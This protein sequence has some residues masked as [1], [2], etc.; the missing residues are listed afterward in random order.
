MDATHD[1]AASASDEPE[2]TAA[3]E[4]STSGSKRRSRKA[5][6]ASPPDEAA[7]LRADLAAAEAQLQ[8]KEQLV[9]ALTERLEQAAE[10]LDRVHRTGGDRRAHLGGF[11]PELV[12]QQKSLV[13]ELQHA[14]ETWEAMQASLVLGRLEVQITELRDLVSERL[15]AAPVAGTMPVPAERLGSETPRRSQGDDAAPQGWEA[16]KAS[17]LGDA[18]PA[19]ADAADG[20][21]DD[22]A[23]D[24]PLEL[25]NAPPPLD[26]ESAN[27][28]ELRRA[29]DARDE[30]IAQLARN[31]RRLNTRHRLPDDWSALANVP[32]ELR[33]RLMALERRL[34][35]SL[36]LAEVETSLE[37]ARLGREAI[38]L[39]LWEEQ[40]QKE[41]RRHTA[42]AG[43]P[44]EA[45]D[46]DPK[47]RRWLR[48]LGMN[49][50]EG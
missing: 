34:E 27:P 35:E 8:D 48:M 26:P 14:V 45:D 43:P 41:A 40:L 47:S 13:D 29:I 12:E 6:A 32:D 33:E 31:L 3:T 49:K 36:R 5:D 19:E 7:R 23:A 44:K 24:E 39:R 18:P 30:F 1:I 2:T 46:T 15:T 20:T 42:A 17:L 16:L 37:R 22:S 11:P 21:A 50:T 9:A 25:E 28:D 4:S 10:Q 38:R